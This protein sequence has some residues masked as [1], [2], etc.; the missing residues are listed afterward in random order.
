MKKEK[1][2]NTTVTTSYVGEGATEVLNKMFF[3]AETVRNGSI[4]IKDD[5]NKAYFIRRLAASGL[6]SD[7]TCAF[8]ATGS[9]VDVDERA[10]TPAVLS[11]MVE[12][13]KKDFKHV[14]WGSSRMGTGANRVLPPEIA[15]AM[16]EEILGH[17]GQ[18]LEYTI[19]QGD[20]GGATYTRFDGFLK[21]MDADVP[22]GNKTTPGLVTAAN[23]VDTLAAMYDKAAEQ[24]WFNAPRIAFWCPPGVIAAYKQA[25]AASGYRDEYQAGDKPMNYLGVPMW[26]APGIEPSNI[27]LSHGDNLFFGTESVSNLNEVTLLDMFDQDLSDNV[28]FRAYAVGG[29]QIG[30]P[31]EVVLHKDAI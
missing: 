18:E 12:M 21:I 28:R 24:A 25:L 8:D 9:T 26:L 20:T 5:V 15:D 7:L 27:V 16:I 13:C 6:I 3:A 22:V 30:W 31:E 23:V 1:F 4:T 17:V 2:T 11:V 14:D 29:V 19:W 10:L